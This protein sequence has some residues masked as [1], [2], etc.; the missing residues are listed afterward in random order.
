MIEGKS[1]AK[2]AEFCGVHP[3]KAFRWRHRFL[4]AP[5]A[6]KPRKLS[7]IVEATKPSSL[8]PSRD[9]G[10]ICRARRANGAGR[11]G[12]WASIRTT[13]PFSSPATGGARPSTQSCR[14]TTAP[15]IG[16]A[17]A[18]VVTG[19]NHLIGDGGKA[20]AAFARKAKIPFHAVPAPGKPTARAHLHI[21][22]VNAYEALC[23]FRLPVHKNVVKSIGSD[24]ITASP[25]VF[26]KTPP[27]RRQPD[28]GGYRRAL[29]SCPRT[30]DPGVVPAIHALGPVETAR[31]A[32][33]RTERFVSGSLC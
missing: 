20:I 6:D 14:R 19:E 12:I 1:L 18:G 3:T 11:L 2:T 23:K 31:G 17:L 26:Q 4:G 8:N 16:V 10:L 7:G 22:N 29:P 25:V 21:N 28:R 13:F 24:I 27:T 15:R 9:G 33:Q 32:L 30:N 5:A